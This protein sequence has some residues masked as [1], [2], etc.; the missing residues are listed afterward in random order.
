MRTRWSQIG[1]AAVSASGIVLAL[2]LSLSV[3]A[4]P[5]W[6]GE[7]CPNE[8]RRVEQRA[9]ALPDCR[10]YE[11]VS[12]LRSE[13]ERGAHVTPVSVTG[14]RVGFY[15]QFGPSSGEGASAGPYYMSSRGPEGWSTTD[16]IPPQST[17][18]GLFC[19]PIVAGYS[20]DLSQAVLADGWN[21]TGYPPHPNDTGTSQSCGHDEP[22]L[23]AG[24]GQGAQNIFLHEAA[25][26]N[27]A[28]FYELL[29]PPVPGP[30]A[31]DAY[32]QAGSADFSHLAFTSPL[33]LTPEAPLPPEQTTTHSVGEDLYENVGGAV[34]LVTVLPGG[35]PAWGILA[36]GWESNEAPT[37]ASFTHAVSE[38]GE[39]VFF[40]GGGEQYCDGPLEGAAGTACLGL[41][42][43]LNAN[44]Y[45][46]ENV[47]QE[48]SAGGECSAGEAGRACT[49]QVDERNSDAPPGPGGHGIFQWATPDGSRAFFT[50]CARLTA[51]AT[52]VDSSGCGGFAKTERGYKQPTGNDLYEFDAEKPVGQRL[53]DLTVDT[54]GTD[55]LGADVQGVAGISSDGSYVYFVALGVLTG[56]EE[57]AHHEKAIAGEANLYLRHA[58]TTTFIAVLGPPL[59]DE[60]GHPGVKEQIEACDWAAAKTPE[61]NASSGGV[62][63]AETRGEP[64][65][66][67]RVTP[68]GRFLAF[69]S[70]HSLTGY[71]STVAASGD[72]SFEIFRYDAVAK[73]LACASC[74]PS[75]APPTA[76][77]TFEQPSILPPLLTGEQW[78]FGAQVLPAQ[79]AEDGKVFFST[80]DSLLPSDTGG[81]NSDVYEYDGSLHLLS[82]GTGNDESLF[83]N[84]SPS[85]ND[86]FFTTADAL[87]SSDTD[88]AT[89][90]YDARVDGGFVS[91]PPVGPGGEVEA[92]ACTSA[93][94]CKPPPGASPVEPFAASSAFDGP[95]NLVVPLVEPPPAKKPKAR[96]CKKGFRKVRVRGKSVCKRVRKRGK[97]NKRGKRKRPAGHRRKGGRK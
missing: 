32:F 55:A 8:A 36:N 78:G 96:A 72:P 37:S 79:L 45:L 15:T 17:I 97:R 88:E 18:S 6:A 43:Y 73:E 51:D 59:A 5:A 89:S 16:E 25:A 80:M 68:D 9:T 71:D 52:A 92:P 34:H 12:P 19:S 95:G 86:V 90:L 35:V 26:P 20:A 56:S 69:I 3:S 22:L 82:A 48:P 84:A 30:G 58:G 62:A 85:G 21:W 14:D 93:E 87:V 57:N 74:D 50:D 66:T 65:L 83:R 23:V 11:L 49:V 38:D 10:A 29:D 44:L 67:S 70:H 41:G 33:Q 4:A 81:E 64:C 27:E 47:A 7:G 91:A 63:G 1:P 13:P 31:R 28:G 39:R 94:A 2:I 46:R 75:G 60:R 40:Y 61:F 76:A 54:N 77:V 42:A 53:V 24:E